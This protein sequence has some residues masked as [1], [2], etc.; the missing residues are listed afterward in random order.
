MLPY[1]NTD[2]GLR[3]KITG[4]REVYLVG[5]ISLHHQLVFFYGALWLILLH[6]IY[7]I[8]SPPFGDNV[9]PQ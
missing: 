6:L 8:T 4:E 1:H 5:W 7:T 9:A 3:G 2:T